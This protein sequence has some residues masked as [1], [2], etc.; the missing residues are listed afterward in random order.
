MSKYFKNQE[1]VDAVM[2]SKIGDH[3][4]IIKAQVKE[5]YSKDICSVCGSPLKGH[6]TTVDRVFRNIICPGKW[7]ITHEDGRIEYLDDA[8]FKKRYSEIES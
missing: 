4:D 1:T 2:W 8:I 3:P 7:I 6:G 5:E